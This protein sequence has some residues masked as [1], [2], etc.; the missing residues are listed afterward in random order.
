YILTSLLIFYFLLLFYFFFISINFY[1][2]DICTNYTI[3][4]GTDIPGFSLFGFTTNETINVPDSYVLT[5]VNVTV[6]IS[7][8]NN[9]DLDIYLI[10]PTGTTVELSTDNGGSGNNYNNVTFDDALTNNTLPTGNTTLSGTYRPE[11]SLASFNG[12]NANGNWTL[13]VT[14]DNTFNLRGGT[15]NS[16]TLNLCYAATSIG[17]YSGPGGVGNVGN[18]SNLVLWLAAD[19]PGN[20]NTLWTDISGRG[21]NFNSGNAATLNSNDTNDYSSYSFNGSNQY[22]EKSYE[23][24]LN[25]ESF[26]ILTA[27]NVSPSGTYKALLSSRDEFSTTTGPSWKPTTTLNTRGYILYATPTTNNWQFWT[28]ANANPQ[29]VADSRLSTTG[30]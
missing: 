17:G 7:H 5:D 26:S 10:S 27:S 2:Q 20:S 6:N 3:N 22:L 19:T 15:I 1:A 28:G 4:P 25:P 11:G 13:R 14:D 9:A 16:V 8:T 24:I 18:S 23:A 30:S 21:F 12:Q 29:Q